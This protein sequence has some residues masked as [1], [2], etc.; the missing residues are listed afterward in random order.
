MI[1]RPDTDDAQGNFWLSEFKGI[2]S[3]R[4]QL[5]YILGILYSL[6]PE[7]QELF[8]AD[9]QKMEKLFLNMNFY[10]EVEHRDALVQDYPAEYFGKDYGDD[11]PFL[12]KAR[13]EQQIT[14][15]SLELLGILGRIIKA[16]RGKGI[17]VSDEA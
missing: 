14:K 6:E 8:Q 4:E 16:N 13:T 5:S 12:F 11:D 7:T 17:N 9:M 3:F 2:K 10:R 15:L 1:F